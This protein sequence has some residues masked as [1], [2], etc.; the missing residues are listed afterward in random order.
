M[1]RFRK[2]EN[3]I[4]E[5]QELEKQQIYFA[6]L[7]EL[8]DPME[9]MRRY[10]WQGDKIVWENF[11][12]HYL[13][14]LEHVILLARLLPNEKIIEK[15]DIPI[16]KSEKDLP[17]EIYKE[18]IKKINQQFFSNQ[19][20]HSYFNFIVKNP[21]KIYIEE[22]YVHLTMLSSIAISTIFE[23]DVQE[24][25]L[26]D[27]VNQKNEIDIDLNN[28][29]NNHDIT[30]ESYKVYNESI[31][32]LHSVIKSRES[33]LQIMYKDSPKLQSI[34]IEFTQMYLDSIIELTYPKAYVACFM[35]N[36]SN[37]S[38]WGTYGNNHTGIC[39][40]FKFNDKLKP[41]LPLKTITSF[42]SGSGK[43][44]DYVR[45]SLQPIDYS[46]NFRDLDFFRNLGRLP[47]IQL[48]EQWYTNENGEISMCGEQLFTN[49]DEW[50]SAYWSE[51]ENAYL[52][53]LPSW[54]HE[55]EYRIVI[56]SSL[57]SFDD[58]KD[59]VL[60]Y[61]FENL[62]AII[63][64]MK[65]PLKQRSEIIETVV[66]KCKELNIDQFDFYEMAYSNR[67]GTLFKRKLHSVKQGQLQL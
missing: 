30:E 61:K 48:K 47:R 4:G 42:S 24:G 8:N 67:T 50:R 21:N 39:L 10:F 43:I 9:G 65:T 60:E 25:L 38:I 64:G 37:S 22:M 29:W 52:K 18:R 33:A 16:F 40:K 45:H 36:C 53:K 58:A 20:V 26:S 1:Y 19:F 62:E 14:C 46:S 56:S 3:L 15:K 63:F 57:G 66:K 54:S 31:E 51:Y 27:R 6:D 49:P 59:R 2:V 12:K 11:F 32:I 23:I 28:I 44:Y 5:F 13:L 41:F 7:E 55:K 34:Y 17:T 35:D